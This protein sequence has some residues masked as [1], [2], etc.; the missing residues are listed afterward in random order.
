MTED[1]GSATRTIAAVLADV[2]GTLVTRD[3]VLTPR[4]VQAVRQLQQRGVLFAVTSGRPTRG[5]GMLV[6]PLGMRVPMAAFNGGSIVLPDLTV[7]DERV[8]P[9]DVAPAVVE[10]MREHGLDTWIYHTGDWYVTDPDAPHVQ[11]ESRTVRF[12]PTVVPDFHGLLDRAVKIVGVS[13]EH[14]RTARCEAALQHRFASTVSAAR[15]QP[16]YLDVTYPQANKGVVVERLSRYFDVPLRQIATLGDQANDVLMF[17]RSG[18]SI[19]MGNASDEVQRHATY[20]TDSNTDEGFAAA[21]DRF[22]LPCA[23]AAPRP[24]GSGE[25]S[26]PGA[27]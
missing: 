13:D 12:A 25:T 27:V 24:A 18:M 21:I 5:L 3:K 4:A 6:E 8:V 2:D 10:A 9:A 14:D 11:R 26:A 23:V 20:V 15:S 17:R 16:Y 7:V 22:V 19:A 1:P